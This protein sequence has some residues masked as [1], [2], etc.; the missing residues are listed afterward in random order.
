MK[1]YEVAKTSPVRS[2]SQAVCSVAGCN[3][4]GEL[5]QISFAEQWL[6]GPAAGRLPIKAGKV[7]LSTILHEFCNLSNLES[8]RS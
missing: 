5:Y 3:S 4:S 1:T 6:K 2:S 7:L 8:I